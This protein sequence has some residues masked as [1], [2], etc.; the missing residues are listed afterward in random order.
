[1]KRFKKPLSLLLL[2]AIAIGITACGSTGSV[3]KET[4]YTNEQF[5]EY[6]RNQPMRRHSF[7]QYRQGLIEIEEAEIKGTATTTFFMEPGNPDPIEECPSIGFPLPSTAELTNPNQV[8]SGPHNTSDV[9]GQGEP[10]GVYTG[11]STGT[12]VECVS[13]SG[14]KYINYWEG[15]TFAVGGPAHW[16]LTT[17][18]AVLDG[19]PT[20]TVKTVGK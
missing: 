3:T 18:K 16:D 10:N 17:H 6:E 12:Y 7:S 15:F 5:E 4:K 20:V 8:V 11:N 13:K 9:V 14:T 2:L 19:E 1:M